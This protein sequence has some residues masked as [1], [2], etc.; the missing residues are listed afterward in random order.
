[1]RVNTW[2]IEL[3]TVK[4]FIRKKN[5]VRLTTHSSEKFLT[6]KK[7]PRENKKKNKK[8][9]ST[10]KKK[11]KK[12]NQSLLDPQFLLSQQHSNLLSCLI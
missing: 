7:K 4:F 5:H 12:K 10:K 11:K 1:M 3:K 2:F 8:K 9:N 6:K